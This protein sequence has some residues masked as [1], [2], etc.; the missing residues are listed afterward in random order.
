MS[1]DSRARPWGEAALWLLLLAPL[2]FLFY[3]G[4]GWV[5]SLQP[6]V[7]SLHF[8][9]E[10]DMPFVPAMIVPYVSIDLFFA[11]SLFLCA[12]RQALRT[13]A[14]RIV[15]VIAV[16]TVFFLLFPLKFGFDRPQVDGLFGPLF[17]LLH[18][19]DR[20]YNLAPS[21]HIALL[22]V[23]WPVFHRVLRGPANLA[24]HVWFAL[25]GAS[26]LLTWQHHLID[27]PT[28]ALLGL[29]AR[30]LLP[31]RQHRRRGAFPRGWDSD[32]RRNVG[33]NYRLGCLAL[34]VLSPVALPW[35]LALL[36]PA[37]SLALVAAAYAWGGP[38]LLGKSE[39]EL[40][41]PARIVLA[42]YR[43]GALVFVR[44][45]ATFDAPW[46]EVAP[47][48]L[49]GRLL[50]RREARDAMED[51][52][53]AVLDLTAEFA[54]CPDFLRLPYLNLPVLDLTAPHPAVLSRAVRFVE[55]H[56]RH[57]K[58]YVHC[59]LGYGRSACVA[60]ACLLASGEAE[61]VAAAVHRVRMRRSKAVFTRGVLTVLRRRLARPSASSSGRRPRRRSGPARRPAS[62]S[63]RPMALHGAAFD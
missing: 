62:I 15:L 56:R 2:F 40:S 35:S 23:L 17:S 37:S 28:G 57:G 10:R 47:G 42:P 45:R 25:I 48:L 19:L 43:L 33:R 44:L 20:P 54:E 6:D 11:I 55:T 61:S 51:G 29:T 52:V 16:T 3:G 26:V 41:L 27:V 1:G 49:V 39:G 7:P 34:L 12:D 60:A 36:W 31:E 46:N 24:L 38:A 13:H 50:S 14:A 63:V 4:A 53:V 32:A 58:V 18:T 59:A 21:L 30:C 5:A 9:W 22:V 8:A